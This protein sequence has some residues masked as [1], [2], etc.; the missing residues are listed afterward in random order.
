MHVAYLSQEAEELIRFA[1]LYASRLWN[2]RCFP[3]SICHQSGD[4]CFI[5]NF[6]RDF[7]N[8]EFLVRNQD[9]AGQD[10]TFF[11]SKDPEI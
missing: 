2:L 4:S 10:P 1:T 3:K 11:V 6:R 7:L 9:Q 8:S 5:G